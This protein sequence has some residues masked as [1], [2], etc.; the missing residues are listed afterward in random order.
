MRGYV[1]RSPVLLKTQNQKWP[2]VFVD[3]P[4]TQFKIISKKYEHIEQG[5]IPLPQNI[6]QLWSQHQYS[7]MARDEAEYKYIG[8]WVASRKNGKGISDI[9]PEIV[10]LL[11]CPPAEGNMRKVI[12]YMWGYVSPYTT[13]PGKVIEKKSMQGLLKEIQHLTFL[14]NIVY[15]KESTAL[16]EL[17]AW[18][19]STKC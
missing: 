14:H 10:S 18:T 6:Q 12:Q 4:A 3:P 19:R 5:R 11:R 2:E 9:Y 13:F 15:L 17:P 7:V 8:G 16:G 1:D